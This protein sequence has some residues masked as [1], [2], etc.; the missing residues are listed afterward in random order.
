MKQYQ[1]TFHSEIIGFTSPD[2]NKI[3]R[4]IDKKV[5]KGKTNAIKND[6]ELHMYGMHDG[7]PLLLNTCYLYDEKGCM[8]HG[9][10]KETKEYLIET[11]RYHTNR[12]SKG[13]SSTRIRPCTTK[14]GLFR[15]YNDFKKQKS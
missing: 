15:L 5:E 10:I 2:I 12:S 7:I 6:I 4:E 3:R 11:W 1:F 13:T 9:N 14:A 8:V